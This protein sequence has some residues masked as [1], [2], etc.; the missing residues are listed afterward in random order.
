MRRGDNT[1]LAPCQMLKVLCI[2]PDLFPPD[3]A[4]VQGREGR[5]SMA[6]AHVFSIY[7]CRLRG[8]KSQ[9]IIVAAVTSSLPLIRTPSKKIVSKLHLAG[10]NSTYC[11]RAINVQRTLMLALLPKG[12]IVSF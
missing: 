6:T 7:I 11:A 1:L 8:E 4:N 10:Q 9:T 12:G 2:L 3:R 5:R